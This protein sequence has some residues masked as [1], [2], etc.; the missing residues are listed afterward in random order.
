MPVRRPLVARSIT[1][2]HRA[3]SQLEL[4]FDLTFVI[5]VASITSELAHRIAD[6]H[7]I[8]G[9]IP[10]LQVFF[11]IWW[12][13]MNFTWFA[14]AYDNGDAVFRLLA[15]VQMA[16]VLVLAAGVPAALNNGD[17][18]AITLGYLI[19]RIGL[20]ALWVR[21]A[22][23][24]PSA[25]ITA[26]RYASGVAL[27]EVAWILRLV[28]AEQ[29][30]LPGGILLA[31]FT[32]LV[33]AELLVPW[34]AERSSR[35]DSTS[36][37]PRHIA[38]RYGLFAI[39]LLGESLLATSGGVTA[40]LEGG[41]ANA[42]I[43]TVSAGGFLLTMAL[44]WLYFIDSPGDGLVRFRHRSFQW[45]Y[46]HYGIFAS[47]AALGAGLEVA[48]E[49]TAGHIKASAVT[50]SYSVA[51]P[52]AVFLVLLAVVNAP[53]VPKLAITPIATGV[54]VAVVLTIPLAAMVVDPSLVVAGIGVICAGLVLVGAVEHR[55]PGPTTTYRPSRDVHEHAASRAGVASRCRIHPHSTSGAD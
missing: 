21:A 5:A 48:A 23:D 15:M 34:W 49:H 32:A 26:L 40:A 44:W 19:S 20:I 52:V 55:R 50:V 12:A 43:I 46:M 31:M 41:A 51:V 45:G 30:V 9:I 36:W 37:H 29:H 28:V 8:D 13:W 35:S 18:R 16:G 24:C 38:E 1:E 27:L 2:D 6:G 42:D 14:S 25:R 11:A 53:L 3:A 47:L 54:S 39:I 22:I 7:P 10:F 4:L 33:A 17:Y